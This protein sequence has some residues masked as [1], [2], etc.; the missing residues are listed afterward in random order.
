M[1]ITVYT[2][3]GLHSLNEVLLSLPDINTQSII[4][5][6]TINGFKLSKVIMIDPNKTIHVL[7][8]DNEEISIHDHILEEY[9]EIQIKKQKKINNYGSS[10]TL[11]YPLNLLR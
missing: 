10:T 5:R 9:I 6:L 3:N 11:L 7:L 8:R 2:Y 4:E 1:T